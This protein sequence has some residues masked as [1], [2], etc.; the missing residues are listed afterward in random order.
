MDSSSSSYYIWH[1]A[2][3]LLYNNFNLSFLLRHA[4]RHI[5][6]EV[7]R[8]PDLEPMQLNQMEQSPRKHLPLCHSTPSLTQRRSAAPESWQ[9][10]H[11]TLSR[12]SVAGGF[13]TRDY[14]WLDSKENRVTHHV[15]VPGTCGQYSSATL[16]RSIKLNSKES[17]LSMPQS[18]RRTK[19][20][21]WV[22]GHQGNKKV[23]FKDFV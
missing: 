15:T 20:Y 4:V 10:S 19:D 17:T 7:Q 22:D 6:L 12:A 3:I 11:D 18:Q 1:T 8:P 5:T 13:E 9:G 23:T 2:N 14:G 21:G 16:P